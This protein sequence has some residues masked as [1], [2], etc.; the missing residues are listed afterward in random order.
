MKSRWIVLAAVTVGISLSPL[1][2]P[3][4]GP[5]GVG[6]GEAARAAAPSRNPMNWL[7]KKPLTP[8]ETLDANSD[9]S[10]KLTSLLQRQGLLGANASLKDTCETFKDLDDCVATLHAGHNIGVNFNCLKS[11][12]T[13]VQVGSNPSSCVSVTDGK[14]MSLIKAVHALEPGVDAKAE[15]IQAEKQSRDELTEASS[16]P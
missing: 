11:K 3:A 6:A 9:Q 16:A 8:G 14:P 15:A 1:R 5:Q 7:K 13:G 10:A 4:Q 2:S 12:V